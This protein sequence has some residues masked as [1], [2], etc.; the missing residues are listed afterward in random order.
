[1]CRILIVLGYEFEVRSMVGM[2]YI[3]YL[4]KGF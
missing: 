4:R 2:E 3:I 1:M